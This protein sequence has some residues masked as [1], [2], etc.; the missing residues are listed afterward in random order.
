MSALR[1]VERNLLWR[2]MSAQQMRDRI[3]MFSKNTVKE[4]LEVLVGKGIAIRD[5]QPMRCGT[6]RCRYRRSIAQPEAA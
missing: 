4:A 6:Y 1:E 2:P 3:G 5:C